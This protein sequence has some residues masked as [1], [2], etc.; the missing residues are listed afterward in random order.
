MDEDVPWLYSIALM[1]IILLW[2]VGAVVFGL[3][4]LNAQVSAHRGNALAARGG[5]PTGAFG[6]AYY[7]VS[8]APSWLPNDA[9]RWGGS[10]LGIDVPYASMVYGRAMRAG[11]GALSGTERFYPGPPATYE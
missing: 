4:H 1:V 5:E 8:D 7:G 3:A 2:V 9:L 6:A 10:T 11:G